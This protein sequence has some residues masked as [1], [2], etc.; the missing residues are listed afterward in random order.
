MSFVRILIHAVWGTKHHD[1]ILSLDKRNILFDHIKKN[2]LIKNI[3]IDTIGGHIDHIPCFI[4]LGADQSISNVIQLI[5]GESSFWANKEGLF[6]NK[7]YWAEDYFAA[8]VSDSAKDKV[9]TYIKT[10]DEHH[11]KISFKEEYDQFIK[12]Y[13]FKLG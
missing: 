8:S 11:K 4:S 7:L 9:R 5:K 12:S 1:S 13:G 3:H 6:N 2:A 10:Q